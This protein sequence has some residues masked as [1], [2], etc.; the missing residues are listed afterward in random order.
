MRLGSI[1]AAGLAKRHDPEFIAK[2]DHVLRRLAGQLDID[3]D[4]AA[5]HPGV[6]PIGMQRLLEAFRSYKGELENLVPAEV[7]SDDSYDRFVMIMLR[8]NANL[9]SAF[10]PEARVKLYALIV[11]Q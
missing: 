2:L 9:Y 4:L 6:S 1:S 11:F 5:R 10:H 3:A 8:I 7:A